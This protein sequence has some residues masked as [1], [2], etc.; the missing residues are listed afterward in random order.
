M[1]SSIT[2]THR[3]PSE[4]VEK[5]PVALKYN[6]RASNNFSALP[7]VSNSRTKRD[8]R[9]WDVPATGGYFGGYRTG[10]AMALAFAKFLREDGEAAIAPAQL[11]CIVESFMERYEQEGGKTMRSLPMN[12]YSDEF[13]SFRGQYVG[14]FNTITK[15]L[16]DAAVR[17]GGEFDRTSERELVDRANAG[18]GFRETAF[19]ES[20]S[21]D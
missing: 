12:Q 15:M 7:F 16:A 6:H 2:K 13:S 9:C 17:L 14:F 21:D 11:T 18:L 4:F 19:L 3:L 10:E 1:S 8:N 5:P 20:L